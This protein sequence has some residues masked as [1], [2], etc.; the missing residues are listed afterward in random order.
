MSLAIKFNNTNSWL[1]GFSDRLVKLLRIEVSRNRTR[2]YMGKNGKPD[3]VITAPIDSSGSLRSSLE[4]VKKKYNDGFGS[5]IMGND[6]A[7][8]IND[9]GASNPSIDSLISWIRKKPVTLQTTGNRA[10][11]LTE[12]RIKHLAKNIKKSIQ[13]IGIQKTGFIDDALKD[14]MKEINSIH[15]PLIK[16]VELNVDE[17]LNR[18]GYTK[19]G[20]NYII[21]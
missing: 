21:K 1:N 10:V 4:A 11:N 18:A 3:R 16:D 20:D 12:G 14:V 9:G 17:I 2:T 19:Q 6:Y 15:S 7:N 13:S 8:K 5:N